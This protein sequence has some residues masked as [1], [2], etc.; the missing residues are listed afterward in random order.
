MVP[1]E[2]LAILEHDSKVANFNNYL[3]ELNSYP[4][5]AGKPSI[6]QIN[7]G[8]K[9][10]LSCKHCHVGAG[11]NRNEVM[12]KKILEQ[13][14]VLAKNKTI[15]TVDITG[16]APELSPDL[17]WFLDEIGKLG[18]RIIVRTNLVILKDPQYAVFIGSYVKNKVELVS[19]LPHFSSKVTNK[20]RGENTF[21]SIIEILKTLNKVG[22]GVAGSGLLLHL[23]HNPAGAFLSGSQK[24]LEREYKKKLSQ[25]HGITFNDL[26]CL[27]NIPIGRYLEYLIESDNFQDYMCT[28]TKAF[29]PSAV[30]S[31]MCRNTISVSWD[32]R[33]FDCDFNQMLDLPAKVAGKELNLSS[34]DI[35]SLEHRAIVTCNHCYGCV[36]GAGSSC[37]GETIYPS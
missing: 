2:Q 8:K 28:L 33:I 21:D 24:T 30:N 19:S 15:N 27:N 5:K 3:K 17:I 32:G 14:L 10:N 25:E 16:G 29:N 34:L 4:I 7:L 20:Q 26:F 37:Q 6:L 1:K 23:V 36:A 35:D 18:K 9:C 12:D 11:P 13:C 22:Y 31:V